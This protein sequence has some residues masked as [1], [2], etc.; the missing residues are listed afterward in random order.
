MFELITAEPLFALEAWG[1][2][3]EEIDDHHLLLM[4][5]ILG[6]LPP[7]LLS[8]WTRYRD[9]FNSD[10]QSFDDSLTRSIGFFFFFLSH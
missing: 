9:Y 8:K 4:I 1:L 5:D 6:V 7:E 3:Q 2:T 10:G